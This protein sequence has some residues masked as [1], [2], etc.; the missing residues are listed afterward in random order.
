AR[1]ARP[2]IPER[3]EDTSNTSGSDPLQAMMAQATVLMLSAQSLPWVLLE[4]RTSS[5]PAQARLA[6]ASK[7]GAWFEPGDSPTPG[8]MLVRVEPDSA[9]LMS[10]SGEFVQLPLE[11]R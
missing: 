9:T 5:E 8:W 2:P 3:I 11:H 4:V 6:G 1:E 10:Q 7:D